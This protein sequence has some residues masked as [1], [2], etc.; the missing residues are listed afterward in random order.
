M[1][2][3][4]FGKMI[5]D[6]S[7]LEDFSII[8]YTESGKNYDAIYEDLLLARQAGVDFSADIQMSYNKNSDHSYVKQTLIFIKT[9]EVKLLREHLQGN[10]RIDYCTSAAYTLSPAC[11]FK[12]AVGYGV[13]KVYCERDELAVG[14]ILMKAGK[15]NA[16]VF[17]SPEIHEITESNGSTKP[18]L[19]IPAYGTLYKRSSKPTKTHLN[20]SGVVVRGGDGICLRKLVTVKATVQQ[21]NSKG[22]TPGPIQGDIHTR[23][24]AF[25]HAECLDRK[26]FMKTKDFALKK[27]FDA[28]AEAGCS[29]RFEMWDFQSDPRFNFDRKHGSEIQLEYETL[30]MREILTQEKVCIEGPEAEKELVLNG[31]GTTLTKYFQ[32]PLDATYSETGKLKLLIIN[33]KEHDPEKIYEQTKHL[34]TQHITIQ[35]LHECD[36]VHALIRTCLRCLCVRNDLY[37][38]RLT[39]IK[40]LP[41]SFRTFIYGDIN[42]DIYQLTFSEDRA[43]KIRCCKVDSYVDARE[44][45]RSVQA[46]TFMAIKDT[47]GHLYTIRDTGQPAIPP[48]RSEINDY[49]NRCQKT[50]DKIGALF[51]FSW[52]I[53]HDDFFYISGYSRREN[54]SPRNY[55]HVYEIHPINHKVLPEPRDVF[56]LINVGFV[57]NDQEGTVVPWE[58]MYLRENIDTNRGKTSI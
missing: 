17:V 31:L 9:N 14:K 54:R 33:D 42:G 21:S 25:V 58:F 2:N 28:M 44:Y 38:S 24:R 20:V 47:S 41:K 4:I 45:L 55:P 8:T 23:S 5:Q 13:N 48:V 52:T 57:R 39:L 51:N 35:Q 32:L 37:T 50:K 56:S 19:T 40:E 6:Y 27:I 16:Y 34:L 18:I 12:L 36:S 10:M 30:R 15:S 43:I 53:E 46:D 7:D 26:G 29:L 22:D 3:T 1:N 49:N 11:M